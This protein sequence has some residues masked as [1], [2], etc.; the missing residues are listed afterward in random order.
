MDNEYWN[1]G[2]LLTNPESPKVYQNFDTII[3]DNKDVS[4]ELAKRELIDLMVRR[5]P[6]GL[7]KIVYKN[8]GLADDSDEELWHTGY[9]IVHD[10]QCLRD[11]L[12]EHPEYLVMR[13]IAIEDYLAEQKQ[14]KGIKAT[15]NPKKTEMQMDS[16]GLNSNFKNFGVAASANT[17]FD[18]MMAKNQ[19]TT[20]LMILGIAALF[21]YLV[22]YK[23][24]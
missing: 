9:K 22:F 16:R 14:K 5:N 18:I 8:G 17:E 23:K 24:P 19:F 15:I 11:I 12:K 21:A 7:R 6:E 13:K 10:P 1:S 2:D 4:D 3:P 20:N